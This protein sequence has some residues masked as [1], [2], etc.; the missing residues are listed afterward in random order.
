MVQCNVEN[1]PL[2]K[3]IDYT[4]VSVHGNVVAQP[5]PVLRTDIFTYP[6]LDDIHANA[7]TSP[8]FMPSF[9]R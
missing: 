5:P 7:Y 8:F 6:L 4:R 1:A 9:G 2:I 3:L